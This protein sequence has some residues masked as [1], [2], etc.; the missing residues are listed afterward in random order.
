MLENV[1]IIETEVLDDNKVKSIIDNA[2]RPANKGNST[3]ME[4]LKIESNNAMKSN[5]GNLN[6]AINNLLGAK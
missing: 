6:L 4:K 5:L 3:T 1:Q 2:R